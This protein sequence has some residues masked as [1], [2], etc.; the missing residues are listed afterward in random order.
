MIVAPRERCPES[1]S[2]VI[3]ANM[4]SSVS[5]GDRLDIVTAGETAEIGESALSGNVDTEWLGAAWPS[6]NG[7]AGDEAVRRVS[8]GVVRVRREVDK[9]VVY[10]GWSNG[11]SAVVIVASVARESF[12][13]VESVRA[14]DEPSVANAS[15]SDP[16]AHAEETIEL[17]S[18]GERA[19]EGRDG[20]DVGSRI[21]EYRA[22]GG[23]RATTS[24]DSECVTDGRVVAALIICDISGSSFLSRLLARRR[25]MQK[26]NTRTMASAPIVPSTPLSTVD[27]LLVGA[28]SDPSDVPSDAS[29]ALV[30]FK[31]VGY[32]GA[33]AEVD[34]EIMLVGE[35]A[36]DEVA[37]IAIDVEETYCT[38]THVECSVSK[39]KVTGI[40]PV[41][42]RECASS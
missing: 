39:D 28:E 15:I 9:R 29:A 2:S 25:L 41:A 27:V 7:S 24:M 40:S 26:S 19:R 21:R 23:G 11:F 34:A 10:A 4:S 14:M 1:S 5:A 33:Y 38:L 36:G 16:S 37:L 18:R 8:V 6:E 17:R 22:R 32:A 12:E 31:P 13:C 35:A 30:E 20:A 3:S 42:V